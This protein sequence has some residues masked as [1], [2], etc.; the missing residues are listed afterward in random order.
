M[1]II[2]ETG[3]IV[4]GANSFI[5]VTELVAYAADRGLTLG[6][7]TQ[8]REAALVAAADYLRNESR[9][10]YRG[11]R[12]S[13]NQRL[14]FPR[15]GCAEDNGP[16]YASTDIPWRMK[17]AQA[18]LAVRALAG[19]A[20]QPDLERG[21]AVKRSKIDVIE[22]EYFDGAPSETTFADA[23]GYVAPLLRT[24]QDP[25]GV[26]YLAVPEDATPYVPG[27]FDNLTT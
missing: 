13:A 23:M 14:P 19:T 27:E 3:S 25:T 22:T 20:L 11:T 4:A 24:S 15:S 12:V 21:G 7:T 2:V 17:D 16:A 5:D 8:E 26:P 1:P 18:A 9:F 10:K 6:G